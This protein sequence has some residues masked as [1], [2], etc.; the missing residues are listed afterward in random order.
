MTDPT[1]A[2]DSDRATRLGK[3]WTSGNYAKAA[4]SLL[5]IADHGIRV[6]KSVPADGPLISRAEPATRPSRPGR[7]GQW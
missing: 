5:P 3:T 7:L 1:S 4:V 6:A 2:P